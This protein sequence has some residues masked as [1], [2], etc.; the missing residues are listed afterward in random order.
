MGDPLDKVEAAYNAASDPGGA[1][2]DALFDNAFGDWL[3][4]FN[5]ILVGKEEG[6]DNDPCIAAILSKN[7]IE[8][9][10]EAVMDIF[11]ENNQEIDQTVTTNQDITV[12]C[13]EDPIPDYL[14]E[15]EY[16]YN[17]FGMQTGTGCIKYG[18][19]YDIEQLSIS[20]AEAINS[21]ITKMHNEM[22]DRISSSITNN[23]DIE[24][25]GQCNIG[26]LNEAVQ[27]SKSVAAQNIQSILTEASSIDI[28]PGQNI[29]V[30][31]RSP[32]RCVNECD[33]P[34]SA[35]TIKQSI[36]IDIHSQNIVQSTYD[37]IIKNYKDLNTSTTVDIKAVPK[38]KF[39]L[40]AIIS[41]ALFLMIYFIMYLIA[42]GIIEGFICKTK[43]P[44]FLS[45]LGKQGTA[46]LL[47]VIFFVIWGVIAS[48][49]R[50][51]T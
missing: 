1:L 39:Y 5:D 35:G 9:S 17:I 34:P 51:V 23:V 49:W 38:G 47:W 28:R 44:K 13:G 30:K 31:S 2:N 18:C 7:S 12:N 16:D 22:Y 48:A 19:C 14:L 41:L 20:H 24:I 29:V 26:V 11:N 8:T 40:F 46:I 15:K 4:F 33:E 45:A 10:Q 42:I 36:N 6:S 37:T 3:T 43:C 27:K 21:D 32:L 50:T 25:G